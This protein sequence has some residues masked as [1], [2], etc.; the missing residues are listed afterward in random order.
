MAPTLPRERL[1]QRPVCDPRDLAV[2][3]SMDY[4]KKPELVS[5]GPHKV[6]HFELHKEAT[7]QQGGCSVSQ[8][9]CRADRR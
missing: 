4:T 3:F 5:K 8:A 1:V 7:R 6:L 9:A 2:A